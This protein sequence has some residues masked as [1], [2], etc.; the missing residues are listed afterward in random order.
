MTDILPGRPAKVVVDPAL[1]REVA[2]LLRANHA[3]LARVHQGWRPPPKGPDPTLGLA[4]SVGAGVVALLHFDA[5]LDTW[6]TYFGAE[7][8]HGTPFRRAV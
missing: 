5:H 3:L 7:Y 2:D 6:D 8:T 1:S 4:V